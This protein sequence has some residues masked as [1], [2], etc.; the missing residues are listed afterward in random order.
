MF[1]YRREQ[2]NVCKFRRDLAC[3]V[4]RDEAGKH[5]VWIIRLEFPRL[6]PLRFLIQPPERRKHSA[7]A[8]YF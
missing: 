3:R 6:A 1:R 4:A 2:T 7:A 5:R 8:N